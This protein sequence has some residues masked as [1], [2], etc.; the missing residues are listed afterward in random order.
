MRLPRAFKTSACQDGDGI[1]SGVRWRS[2]QISSNARSLSEIVI[3]LSCIASPI[4][5]SSNRGI[6]LHSLRDKFNSIF[7]LPERRCGSAADV[8]ASLLAGTADR[9]SRLM[10]G[11]ERRPASGFVIRGAL[12]HEHDGWEQ[13]CLRTSGEQRWVKCLVL[14]RL[15]GRTRHLTESE[16]RFTPTRKRR[17]ERWS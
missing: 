17:R 10:A 12:T 9:C 5:Q 1:S 8:H 7:I 15:R 4:V 16:P 11:A 13:A 6:T 14:P 2:S 3:L